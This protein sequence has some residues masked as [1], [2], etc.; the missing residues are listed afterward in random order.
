MKTSQFTHAGRGAL[1]ILTLVSGS[2]IGA[3]SSAAASQ[4]FAEYPDLT[5]TITTNPLGLINGRINLEVERA[6]SSASSF[7]F[8][9]N[10]LILKPAV[11]QDVGERLFGIGPEIGLRF[12]LIG[13]APAGIYIGPYADFAYLE[14]DGNSDFGWAAGGALG[15]NLILARVLVL[16][17]GVGLGYERMQVDLDTGHAG[18][19]GFDTRFRLGVGFAF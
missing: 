6:L 9:L 14:K 13:D 10:F 12:Y 2:W 18:A 11:G 15:V 3:A 1:L 8:G 4:A 19:E 7:Y 5:T 17:A 16:T